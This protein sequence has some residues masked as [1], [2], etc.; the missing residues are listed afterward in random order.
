MRPVRCRDALKSNWTQSGKNEKCNLAKSKYIPNLIFLLGVPS[1]ELRV[2]SLNFIYFTFHR[3]SHQ[4]SN[5]REMSLANLNT[6]NALQLIKF[7]CIFFFFRWHFS[8][9]QSAMEKEICSQQSNTHTQQQQQRATAT[10]K[11]WKPTVVAKRKCLAHW[12]EH[13]SWISYNR[14]TLRTPRLQFRSSSSC[15]NGNA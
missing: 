12:R 8:F 1:T 15:A 4:H 10:R 7:I 5:T 9:V 14:I 13:K 6:I 3:T 2:P 11:K